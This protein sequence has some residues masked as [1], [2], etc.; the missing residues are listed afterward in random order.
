M[1][2]ALADALGLDRFAVWGYSGGGPYAVATAGLLADRVTATAVSAGMGQMGAW[3]EADD[4]EKTDRQLLALCARHPR[5]ARLIL[6]VTGW[7]ARRSPASAYK[8]FVKQLADADRP[9]LDRLGEP[10]QAVALF[11]E[12]FQDGARGVVDDYRAI[13]GPWGVDLAAIAGPVRVYHGTADTMVPLA[14]GEALAQRITGADLVCWPGEGHL[15]TITHVEEILD[16][17]AASS[18]VERE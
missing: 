12:A 7:L 3:A 11:T 9:V 2:A 15:G 4:F 6:G 18:G 17:L 1:V 5:V 8:S 10:A 13:G 14:H 16:W